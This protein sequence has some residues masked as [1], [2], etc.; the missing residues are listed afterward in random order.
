MPD[1]D[2]LQGVLLGTAIGDALGL[3]VEGLSPRAIRR[4]FGRVTSY[5][6]LGSTGFI[7][8]DTE[9]SALIAHALLASPD[10]PGRCARSFAWRMVG[11]FWRLPF[12]I[13]LSTLRACL[14]L[15]VGFPPSRSGIRSAG[16]GSAMRA[17]IVGAFFISD[18]A[19]RRT[20]GE[21]LSRV[22]HTDPRA[23]EGARFVA[24]LAAQ[25]A[26]SPADRPFDLPAA[27]AESVADPELREALERADALA[28]SGA[29]VEQAGALGTSGYVVHTVAFAS[30]C[31]AR[32]G[33]DPRAALEEAVN[34]GGDTDT[35]G[36]VVGALV[37]ARHGASGLP[38][39]LLAAL[40][41]GP[42]GRDHLRALGKALA[43]RSTAPRYS[44][45]LLLLRNLAL[46][47]VI[48]AHG[49]RRLLPF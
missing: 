37:G 28:R 46:M 2:R 15:S 16:N 34:A 4:R 29:S 5:H 47:P 44:W 49:L 38:R 1:L 23:V 39:D 20:F 14:K 35:I 18:P 22:T 48:L 10:D 42:L 31:A 6:L 21:A 30:F 12:G 27:L 43:T 7:S 17:A 40:E 33:S 19:R 41:N 24:A 26:S 36:A 13:G 32:F 9:Q 45:P 25:A 8:D 3:A 11:W